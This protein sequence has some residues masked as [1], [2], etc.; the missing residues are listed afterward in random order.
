MDCQLWVGLQNIFCQKVHIVADALNLTV[1]GRL[2][3][4]DLWK[5]NKLVNLVHYTLNLLF[6]DHL[7]NDFLSTL[8]PDAQEISQF[9]ET[10]IQVHLG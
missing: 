7:G 1:E 6:C 8:G 9:L 3:L 5:L 10:D 4:T 2:L